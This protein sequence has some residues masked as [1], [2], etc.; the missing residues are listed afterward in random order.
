MGRSVDLFTFYTFNDAFS[1]INYIELGIIL[2]I[3]N[4]ANFETKTQRSLG[5]TEENNAAF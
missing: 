2:W 3:R 5:A 1:I 4:V